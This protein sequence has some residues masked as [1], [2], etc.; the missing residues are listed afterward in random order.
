[1]TDEE[2]RELQAVYDNLTATQNRC[3][4]LLTEN[5]RLKSHLASMR[6]RWI[7]LIEAHGWEN[8]PDEDTSVFDY[9]VDYDGKLRA[10]IIE[11]DVSPPSHR[12]VTDGHSYGHGDT[13]HYCGHEAEDAQAIPLTVIRVNDDDVEEDD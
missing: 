2:R 5:R 3:T 8:G 7:Q 9:H 11:R 13:C 12:C 4:E 6:L 10:Y 1:V